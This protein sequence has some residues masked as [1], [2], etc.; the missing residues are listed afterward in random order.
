MIFGT[1]FLDCAQNKQK[2][3]GERADRESGARLGG[4]S[5]SS[6]IGQTVWLCGLGIGHAATLSLF[7]VL[8]L[9]MG[10]LV[11]LSVH[12]RLL[13]ITGVGSGSSSPV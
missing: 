9:S 13:C 11:R 2:I 4:L 1:W 8:C 5:L 6:H 10:I 12:L 7:F 3:R